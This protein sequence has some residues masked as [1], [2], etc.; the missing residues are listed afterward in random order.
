MAIYLKFACQ[1]CNNWAPLPC[2]EWQ[3]PMLDE[4][5]AGGG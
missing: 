1:V 2:L 5:S 3:V 4:V